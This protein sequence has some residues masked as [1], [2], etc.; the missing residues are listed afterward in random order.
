MEE[1]IEKMRSMASLEEEHAIRLEGESLELG[2]AVLHGL[3]GSIA[4]D[5]KKHAGIYRTM[6]ALLERGS[7]AIPES[8]A[9]GFA[10]KLEKHIEVETKMREEVRVML[11]GEEDDRVK[12]LLLEILSDEDRHHRFLKNLLEAIIERDT[13]SDEDIWNMIW[14][15]VESHGAPPDHNV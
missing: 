4:H 8:Q 9:D 3:V 2:D 1:K 13:I 12:F 11:K 5:S 14:R 15:D 10:A 7:L 6:V